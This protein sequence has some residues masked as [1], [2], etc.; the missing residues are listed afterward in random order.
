MEVFSIVQ[1]QLVRFVFITVWYLQEFYFVPCPFLQLHLAEFV[2]RINKRS[3][4]TSLIVKV[5]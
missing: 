4:F 1:N 2:L 5:V 3:G